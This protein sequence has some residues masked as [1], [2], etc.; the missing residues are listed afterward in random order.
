MDEPM[1]IT[2]ARLRELFEYDPAVG[3]L[4]WRE[5]P[6]SDFAGPKHHKRWNTCFAGKVAGCLKFTGYRHISLGGKFYQAH[7]LI[8]L[9][10]HGEWPEDHVDHI[11]GDKPNNRIGNLRAVPESVNSKNLP[12]QRN[13]TSGQC[14]V[15]FNKATGKWYAYIRAGGK[16]RSLGFFVEKDGAIA[17]R[18]SAERGLGFH[19][20]HGRAA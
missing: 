7:R 3:E 9:L 17:A 4:V 2:Q 5:R 20:N 16:M 18:K 15:S 12:R 1:I 10:V 19:E 11:D 14:G 6:V 13:N 8:W